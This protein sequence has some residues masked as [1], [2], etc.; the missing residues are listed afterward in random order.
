MHDELFEQPAVVARYRAG[1][2]AESRERFLQQ[3]RAVGYSPAT[4]E[5]MAWALLVVAE[6]V[7]DDGGVSYERLRSTL[8]R[9]VRLKSTARPPS[10]N[11]A[12]LF[13]RCAKA[14]LRSIGALTPEA[15]RPLKF[16]GELRA[17]TE[18]MRV[19]QGLS[20]TTIAGRDEQIRWFCASL[21]SQVRSLDAVTLAHVDAF[22]RAQAQRG[23]SRRSLHTLGGSLRSFFR[24]AA[25]QRWCRSDL[26]SGIEL[27]RLY[28]LE[29]VP[30]APSVEEVGRLLKDTASSDDPVNIRDH[31]ILSLLIYYGL[32][33][34]E[35]ERL[36]L[37]DLDWVAETIHVT[38]PKQR[39]AQ[40]YPMSVPVGE[41][42]LR[43]LRLARPRCSHRA[44]FL[45]IQAPFRPL[46][47]PSITFM[48]RK[49]L[50]KQGVQ[51]NR[52]GA[53]CLRHACASQLLDAGFTLKQI[54]DHLGHRSMDTTRIYTKIDLH[55]LRQ[56]AEIDLGALL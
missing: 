27:P 18:Y 15:Q 36:T 10:A 35:V 29:H 45:T 55:G 9:R 8:L 21:P 43:Y 41:A 40:C 13:L 56:V 1:P 20:P 14:W 6:A 11:T 52:R 39:R 28:A 30:R 26:A 7:H 4:L 50:T 24:Y 2:Y 31:A 48:V 33:R 37:D 53:H 47:G 19:E 42:I 49:R 38:R 17:F 32:R 3:V 22:L 51:L 25:S 16:A 12:K 44:L 46:S 5:S 54:A 23:W 34:G